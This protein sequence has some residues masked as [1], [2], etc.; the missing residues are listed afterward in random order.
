MINTVKRFFLIQVDHGKREIIKIAI[1]NYISYQTD[2]IIYSSTWNAV[3][4]ILV[5]YS[6]NILFK[7]VCKQFGK[8]F[9]ISVEKGNR[10][11]DSN[12]G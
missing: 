7:F 5:D 4:L 12:I 11:P 1:I 8:N 2:I 6:A 9:T 10:A 3:A